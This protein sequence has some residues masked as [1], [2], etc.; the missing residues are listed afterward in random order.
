MQ[1]HSLMYT[2]YNTPIR[3]ITN[4]A[5]LVCCIPIC[6]IPMFHI[7]LYCIHLCCI[8][9]C[10]IPICCIPICC[11][12]LCCILYAYPLMPYP[13]MPYPYMQYP[14]TLYPHAYTR[15]LASLLAVK[16]I[17]VN[18]SPPP[19]PALNFPIC[20]ICPGRMQNFHTFLRGSHGSEAGP[21]L[22]QCGSIVIVSTKN[23]A[24]DRER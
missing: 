19:L 8:P 17:R 5:F 9:I 14:N 23:T 18:F 22:E 10:C 12:P 3:F 11:I 6:C 24:G 7:P 13:L 16:Q 21:F 2:G 20:N 1:H 4:A 15:L